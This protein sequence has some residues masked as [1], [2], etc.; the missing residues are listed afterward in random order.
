MTRW[1]ESGGDVFISSIKP[2]MQLNYSSTPFIRDFA[3]VDEAGW[4]NR[5][6]CMNDRGRL[7]GN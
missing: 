1:S 6:G 3:K 5:E 2:L 4:M 7:L